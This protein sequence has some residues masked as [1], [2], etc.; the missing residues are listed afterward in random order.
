MS[1]GQ[2][3]LHVLN[4]IVYHQIRRRT[5]NRMAWTSDDEMEGIAPAAGARLLLFFASMMPQ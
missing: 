1:A 2:G 5:A 3:V 4:G